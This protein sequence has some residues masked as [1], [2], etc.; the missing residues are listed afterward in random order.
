MAGSPG[1]L[2]ALSA[3]LR[4]AGRAGSL[5]GL[6]MRGG[7][8]AI[9]VNVLGV[10]LAFLSQ[11][12]LARVLGTHEYGLY[13]YVFAWVMMLGLLSVLGFQI[14]LLRLVATYTARQAWDALNGVIR[15]AERR[16]LLAGVSVTLLGWLALGLGTWLGGSAWL[17][18]D[19]QT[20]FLIGLVIVP[21]Y[22]LLYVRSAIAR[23]LGRVF[24]ALAP[25]ATVRE[26]LVLVL[27]GGVALSG[28]FQPQAWFA[29]T[30]LLVAILTGLILIT[31]VKRQAR[32]P[33]SRTV[34]PSTEER[35]E[36]RRA[37]RYTFVFSASMIMLPRLDVIFVGNFVDTATAGAYFLAVRI[38]D[39][40]VFPLI[41]INAFFGPIVARYH[42][43]GQ[44]LSLYRAVLMMIASS[45]G[46]GLVLTIGIFFL[47]PDIIGFIGRDFRLDAS[48]IL[49][50]LLGQ[51]INAATGPTT[52]LL[53]MTGHERDAT[54]IVLASLLLTVVGLS[55]L[56]PQLGT[57]GA[58]LV[59]AGVTALANLTYFTVAWSRLGFWSRPKAN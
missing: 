55:L 1:R 30:S 27:V 40:V 46:I 34:A 25:D 42:S 48:I 59:R 49:L 23:G 54:T 29:I 11:L 7:V 56:V 43:Q 33:A 36:W 17:A 9:S 26:G 14:V 19:L 41:A 50:L 51:L 16:V 45:A 15:Y 53:N 44:R 8:S 39:L 10:G 4:A 20:V 21:L 52:Q 24:L 2:R 38:T 5:G 3:R 47:Y 32:P 28:L 35:P 6:L 22:A 18:P 57:D 12:V 31:L 37:V 13:A 58:A